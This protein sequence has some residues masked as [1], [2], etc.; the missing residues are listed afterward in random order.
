MNKTWDGH[1]KQNKT[2]SQRQGPYVFYPNV[3]CRTK[4]E[5]HE[6]RVDSTGKEEGNKVSE[7]AR[8]SPWRDGNVQSISHACMKTPNQNP[9]L[10]ITR[11]IN[12]SKFWL[13]IESL[14]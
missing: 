14:F 5:W 9:L 1:V 2:H 12:I 7:R 10:D 3:E 6:S 4:S 8:E 11:V 13:K